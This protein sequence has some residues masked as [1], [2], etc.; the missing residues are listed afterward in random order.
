MT[1]TEL[2]TLLDSTPLLMGVAWNIIVPAII[3]AMGLLKGN[4]GQQTADSMMTPQ[5]R[6]MLNTQMLRMQQQQ[7]LYNDVMG[8]ARGLLP[9]RYRGAPGPR[10]GATRETFHD[11]ANTGAYPPPSGRDP[12]DPFQ[13]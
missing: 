12:R 8:M 11:N 13:F 7:P 6:D 2:Q 4:G 5:M 10:G 3:S 1:H 9:K